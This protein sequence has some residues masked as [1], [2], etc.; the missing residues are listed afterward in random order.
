MYKTYNTASDN[1][2][3]MNGGGGQLFRVQSKSQSVS[4][5]VGLFYPGWLL[6]LQHNDNLMTV[7]H[8]RQPFV[9]WNPS[10][11][12][13]R[14]AG[15]PV[16]NGSDDFSERSVTNVLN[17]E[18]AAVAVRFQETLPEDGRPTRLV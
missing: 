6:L 10:V 1:S 5:K 18:W 9:V 16:W 12:V 14:Q 2:V 7:I 4:L 8:T 13:Q 17:L 15:E 3:I 11:G